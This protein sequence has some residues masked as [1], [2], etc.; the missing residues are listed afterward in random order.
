MRRDA[1]NSKCYLANF[2]FHSKQD[3]MLNVAFH[4]IHEMRVKIA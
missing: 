3:L 1:R 2:N 4:F